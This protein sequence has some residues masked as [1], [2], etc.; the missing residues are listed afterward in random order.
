M[1][2]HYFT[3][4]NN[5]RHINPLAPGPPIT[6][7]SLRPLMTS[8]VLMLKDN[9]SESFQV[10]GQILH[11]A[12]IPLKDI[13]A[14]RLWQKNWTMRCTGMIFAEPAGN[15]SAQTSHKHTLEIRITLIIY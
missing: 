9:E 8:S 10:N 14:Q 15:K 2:K 7:M 6:I 11:T 1:K 3:S 5:L 13:P 4:Q 12:K